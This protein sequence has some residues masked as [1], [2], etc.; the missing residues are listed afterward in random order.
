MVKKYSHKTKF[1]GEKIFLVKKIWVKNCFG[2]RTIMH[3]TKMQVYIKILDRKKGLIIIWSKNM[4][5][6]KNLVPKISSICV[7]WLKQIWA[8]KFLGSKKFW[9]KKILVWNYGSKTLDL[10][11]FLMSKKLLGPKVFWV[12]T[13]MGHKN[14]WVKKKNW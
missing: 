3:K 2:Q 6:P 13:I 12:Q 14:L 11:R 5:E 1:F 7:F 9:S 4:L 8:K 10:K